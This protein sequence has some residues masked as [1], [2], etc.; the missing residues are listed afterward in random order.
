MGVIIEEEDEDEEEDE[1][2]D[3][4]EDEEG[5]EEEGE[6]EMY[7]LN[8]DAT[9]SDIALSDDTST[10][11]DMLM[12]HETLASEPISRNTVTLLEI[13]PEECSL[14][15]EKEGVCHSRGNGDLIAKGNATVKTL[16]FG[17]NDGCMIEDY[18]AMPI[19]K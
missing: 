15:C 11:E 16:G 10:E 4:E 5:E 8:E 12:E 18:S 7:V 2:E 19:D 9:L 13:I 3:I 1:A 14:F 6:K 17:R